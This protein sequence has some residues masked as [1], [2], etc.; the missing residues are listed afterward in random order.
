VSADGGAAGAPAGGGAVEAA[1]LDGLVAKFVNKELNW[2]A[3][4]AI[5]LLLLDWMTVDC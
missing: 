4:S 2:F 1:T 5:E 3:M